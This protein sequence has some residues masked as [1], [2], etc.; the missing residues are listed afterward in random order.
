MAMKR[1]ACS[2]GWT[3]LL[4]LTA[5]SAQ[6]DPVEY[7]C[8]E[9]STRRPV[10]ASLVDLSTPEVSCEPTTLKNPSLA[11]P[12][13]KSSA[14]QDLP[15]A[16][17]E[18]S[19]GPS[20]YADITL[21]PESVNLFVRNNP[22]SAR[23]ALN[24]ARGAAT[25]RNGGLRVYRPGTCM[26]GSATNNPCLVHAGPE[27]F[28]FNIPGGTP[29]WEQAGEAPSVTTRVLVAVDGRALLQREQSE[30]INP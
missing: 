26:Y 12:E 28:E 2:L 27:G 30:S 25:R 20:P 18:L 17:P 7:Q 6:S 23:R 5:Q 14:K 3:T 9:K 10:A 24:L 1:L 29:G 13:Q 8:F 19:T 11:T 15:A 22:L 4:V 21:D 16:D